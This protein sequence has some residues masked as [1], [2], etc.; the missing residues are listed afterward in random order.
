MRDVGIIGIPIGIMGCC[1]CY[2]CKILCMSVEV[3]QR[4]MWPTLKDAC[5]EKSHAWK[6]KD[7]ARE[8]TTNQNICLE[9]DANWKEWC[10]IKN[11]TTSTKRKNRTSEPGKYAA[12]PFGVPDSESCKKGNFKTV[13]RGKNLSEKEEKILKL[14]ELCGVDLP[15]P[16]RSV[17]YTSGIFYPGESLGTGSSTIPTKH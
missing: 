2:F 5:M 11:N 3:M 13:L 6:S 8:L 7:E 17:N 9:N 15:N 4:S 16:D 12:H 10:C 1:L 14:A